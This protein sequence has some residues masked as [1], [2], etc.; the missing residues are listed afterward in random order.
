MIDQVI[1]HYRIVEK[2]GGGGMGVVYRAEDLLLGRS[3]ALKFL[4]SEASQNGIAMERFRREAR[5]ASAL[6]HPNICTIYEIGEENGTVFIAMEFLEGNTLRREISG[7]PLELDQLISL[8]I[9][10][11]DALDAAHTE[12]IVHRDIK[13]AN[14]FVTKRGHA[15]ILDFGL[16]KVTLNKYATANTPTIGLPP[17]D[18]DH[19]TFPGAAIG[20]VGYMSPE[21][22]RG[23]E[24]D[25]RSDLFSFGVLIYEMAT[26]VPAFKGETSGIISDLILNRTPAAP[27]R[28]NPELPEDLE[29]I[30]N[31]ALE[32]DRNLRYQHA[33]E[34]RAELLRLKR[35]TESRHSDAQAD[36]E[37]EDP[38][39]AR[40]GPSRSR[41]SQAPSR[42]GTSRRSGTSRV[43]EPDDFSEEPVPP[44][45]K[46]VWIIATVALLLAA[47]GGAVW[48]YQANH[49]P[50]TSVAVL[51]LK[52]QTGDPQLDYLS[53]GIS[54]SLTSDLSRISGL[55][56]TAETI[57]RRYAGRAN[58]PQATGRELDVRAVLTGSI[59]K[60]GN[61]LHIPVELVDVNTG[62]QIWG[63]VYERNLTDMASLQR[64]IA[65][66]VA[67]RLRMTM[68]ADQKQRLARQYSTDPATYDDYL[69]GRYHLAKR[70]LPDFQAAIGYFQHAIDKDPTYAPAYAG[71]ADS[72]TLTAFWSTQ[73]PLPLLQKTKAAAERALE[74]DSTLAEAY[75]SLAYAKTLT[76]FD[77]VGAEKG[78]QQSIELNPK[79]A[80]AHAWYAMLL[81]TPL[82]RRAEAKNQLELARM[83]DPQSISIV[84]NVMTVDYLSGDYDGAIREAST[85][86]QRF[87]AP[88]IDQ[89]MAVA[90]L[91]KN[92]VPEALKMLLADNPTSPEALSLR[93]P[94]LGIAYARSGQ[95]D[96]ALEQLKIA[97]AGV[98]RGIHFAYPLAA[99]CLAVG[100]RDKA[101]KYLEQAYED[102]EGD[103]VFVNVDPMLTG[104]HSDPRFH[105]LLVRMNLSR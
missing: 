66:E 34:M 70:T 32:K 71:L 7:K 28:L 94:P 55:R 77:W 91:A 47:I 63:N 18:E 35:Q 30:I 29:Y 8:S 76:E 74:L 38:S 85:V 41:R 45:H 50:I 80:T 36:V 49:Q 27:V 89:T 92:N 64:D 4:T 31:R 104:L 40:S 53:E 95:R 13:P 39:H 75:T 101:F 84:M 103:I 14:I 44:P 86:R 33:S 81:L 87:S 12:G 61:L 5:A 65:T 99:L 10:I 26:G 96:K 6:S 24:V 56:V 100:D 78:Y 20:T 79:Y 93:A 59:S 21:Q 69:K 54:E 15:K 43:R 1:S 82:G 51:P 52:N 88:Q 48:Y 68:N 9:E 90:Y 83:L 105:N 98:S 22:V 102:R 3:V 17:I 62:S 11:A 42:G 97:E 67:D 58:D 23:R 60:R 16:A 25:A 72:Y 73:P 57:A 46:L 19:L 37:M 2:L